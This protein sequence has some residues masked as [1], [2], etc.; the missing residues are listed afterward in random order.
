MSVNPEE[1][2]SLGLYIHIP[3]CSSICNYCNFNRGLFEDELKDRYLTSLREE[4]SRTGDGSMVDSIFFGGGTPSLLDPIELDRVVATCREVYKVSADV[5]VTMEMN[6]ESCG[7]S[8]VTEVLDAGV[9]RC[10]IGVQSLN[11]QELKRLGRMH[12]AEQACRAFQEARDAGCLNISVDLMLWLPSQSLHDCAESID[13]LTKLEPEHASLYLLEIYPNAPLRDE[14]ARSGWSVVPDADAASM[15]L[16][17]LRCMDEAGYTQ[18][19]I[20]NVSLP[21]KQSRHNLKYWQTGNWVGF[22]CGA[23]SHRA[24]VRWKNISE[25]VAYIRALDRNETVVQGKRELSK[26]EQ[27]GDEMFMGLRLVEGLDLQTIESKYDIDVRAMY[28][29]RLRPYQEAGLLIET[30]SHWRLSRSG[31]LLS[32][33]VMKTFV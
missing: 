19:E 4:I 18:Y 21:G 6:P 20:S 32:N 3:F 26:E 25:I 22:G 7:L 8:Y 12:T 24:G 23:H 30:A 2:N 1:H 17:A 33:E 10:S 9:T 31:M 15:Y 27:L 5:E 13:T 14:M 11:D 16:E 28:G 29:D